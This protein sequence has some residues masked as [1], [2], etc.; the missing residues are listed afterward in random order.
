M[1]HPSIRNFEK[2]RRGIVEANGD[3][4]GVVQFTM[5]VSDTFLRL[6]GVMAGGLDEW[7]DIVFRVGQRVEEYECPDCSVEVSTEPFGVREDRCDEHDFDAVRFVDEDGEV[8]EEY[9]T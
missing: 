1:D 4:V 6:Q 8:L 9:E 3:E 5:E 2:E 7:N